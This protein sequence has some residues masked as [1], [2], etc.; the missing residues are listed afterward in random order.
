MFV[1]DPLHGILE[2]FISLGNS[3]DGQFVV[4]E[5]TFPWVRK[6]ISQEQASI[7]VDVL[8]TVLPPWESAEILLPTERLG[9]AFAYGTVTLAHPC[10]DER[11]D[12]SSYLIRSDRFARLVDAELLRR[13]A[14]GHRLFIEVLYDRVA[15]WTMAIPA[16]RDLIRRKPEHRLLGVLVERLVA[17]GVYKGSLLERIVHRQMKESSSAERHQLVS[18]LRSTVE[19]GIRNPW[20]PVLNDEDVTR[21]I[22]ILVCSVMP[23]AD[24]RTLFGLLQ[25]VVSREILLS[26][27]G[28]PEFVSGLIANRSFRDMCNRL[29]GFVP[30]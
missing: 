7:F 21:G 1:L 30:S 29:P 20:E 10:G 9:F 27:E 19:S 24:A 18:R 3:F 5:L 23:N 28:P 4:Q 11:Q 12:R 13:Q 25:K 8:L 6:R 14:F 22:D 16:L 15:A 26:N 17:A 2:K